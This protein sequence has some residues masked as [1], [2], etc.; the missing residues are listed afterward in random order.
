M[1][2]QEEQEHYCLDA[3]AA[4]ES[5]P[6]VASLMAKAMNKN[7]NWINEQVEAFNKVAKNYLPKN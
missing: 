4:M 7:E 5:A 2:L 6:I 1:R 3:K